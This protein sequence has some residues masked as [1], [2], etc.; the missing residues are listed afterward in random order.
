MK[1]RDLAWAVGLSS[2]A[3]LVYGCLVESNL[4]TLERRTLA[5]PLWPA[6]M[7]GFRLAVLGDLH[8]RGEFSAPIARQAISMA[9][10]ERPDA[11]ALVGDYVGYWSPEIADLLVDVLAPL[12]EME[13]R[14]VAVPGNHDYMC[15]SAD[16][17]SAIMA[18]IGIRLLRNES[19]CAGNVFWVGVDSYNAG[20]ADPVL[21]LS[22]PGTGPRIALWHEPDLVDA[23]P[24]GCALML[25]GH[26]HGGQFTFWGG[27][28]PMGSVNGIRYLRGFYPDASTP[29]YVTRGVGTTGP[30]SRLNC[31][32]EVSLL[33]LV[34]AS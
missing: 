27:Y 22:Q 29:L 21:A 4:L 32:P 24:S 20:E 8:L 26:S 12:A 11:I 34:P 33:T 17:L 10:A 9:L 14:V 23:L 28:T 15:G 31:T 13:G 6:S 16:L 19:C 30:P 5:L 1:F 3:T 2:A 18:P 25:S 7:S